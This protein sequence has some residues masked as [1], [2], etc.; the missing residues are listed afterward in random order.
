MH[1]LLIV[2]DMPVIV[3]GLTELFADNMEA[4]LELHKAYSVFEALDILHAVKIDIV[5][6]DIKMPVKSGVDLLKDIRAQWPRC[7]VIF[8]T[9]YHDFHYAR[10]AAAHGVFDF[11][12]KTEGDARIVGAVRK[13]ARALLDEVEAEEMIARANAQFQAAKPFLQREYGMELLEGRSLSPEPRRDR[14]RRLDIPLAA[15]EPVYL[16]LGRLDEWKAN[17]HE[18]DLILLVYS[19]QN[20][21]GEY[22]TGSTNL[23][24]VHYGKSQLV[25]FLQPRSAEPADKER[26]R[27]FRFLYG[28]LETVQNTCRELLQL[29]V[30][31]IV[32][33]K[34]V[35]WEEMPN[36]FHQ[37][38]QLLRSGLGLNSELLTTDVELQ[39]NNDR[40]SA[41]VPRGKTDKPRL[42]FRH[43]ARL[44]DY[45]GNG[46]KEEFD[47]LL[48][49]LS[50]AIREHGDDAASR[51]EAYHYLCYVLLSNMNR[52]D[53]AAEAD[54]TDGA[55]SLLRYDE[56]VPWTTYADSFRRLAEQIFRRR[57]SNRNEQSNQ[58]VSKLQTYINAHLRD[59]LSLTR[60]GERVHLNP[61][62]LSRLYKQMTGVGLS[63]YILD[64][65]VRTAT[66]LLRQG[67]LKIHEIAEAV[68]Y[69]SGIAFTRFFKK[70]MH[71]TPQ[72]YR[73]MRREP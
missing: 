48:T 18:S 24:S 71:M 38:E 36:Q 57:E 31:F 45:I 59:D 51:L 64:L 44:A 69:Q 40:Q 4:E 52:P 47:D 73:D 67:E 26:G 25:W 17:M 58:V 33:A 50:N 65:R 27:Q 63:E 29:K 42:R 66:Q 8:L 55:D 34:P 3:D 5:L 2:D 43:Y 15:E 37:L 41:V 68:G 28:T 22:L 20:I 23:L 1:R 21:L 35:G 61:S 70:A 19:L 56:R 32:G 62:Y 16:L 10:E 72:E 11:I 49:E 14:F 54:D 60:L 6:S 12:M 30:S 9:S 53:A 13:A 39:Q 7:K 46:Q